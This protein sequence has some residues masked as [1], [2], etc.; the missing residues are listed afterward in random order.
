MRRA[1]SEVIA[2]QKDLGEAKVEQL[3]S[4]V[5]RRVQ[6]FSRWILFR[7]SECAIVIIN[8]CSVSN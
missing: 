6:K 5:R 4:S 3:D 1:I 8:L 2:S 7:Q